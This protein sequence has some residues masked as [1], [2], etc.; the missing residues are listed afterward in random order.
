MKHRI[1]TYDKITRGVAWMILL[2]AVFS[3]T[4]RIDIRTEDAPERLVIYGYITNDTTN[5]IIRLTR[6]SGYFSVNPPEGLTDAVVT[7]SSENEV[8]HL[9]ESP[10]GSGVYMTEADVCG[11]AGETYSLYVA[12]DFD[13]DGEKEEFGASSYMPY[14]ATVDYIGF[15]ESTAIDGVLE[16]LLY[17]KSAPNEENYY[18]F[19]LARNEELLN[20]SLNGVFIISDEYLQHDEFDGLSCFFID[21]TSERYKISA[22]DWVS[23]RVDV[24]TNEY[25]DF[26]ENAADEAGG[27]VPIFSGPPANVETNIRSIHN[28]REIPVSGFFSAYSGAA[29]GRVFE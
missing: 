22:G 27:S 25:A 19:H 4:E 13:G 5:H 2:L 11:T 29:T 16:I 17:G 7:I 6:S 18:S 10:K 3:C 21:Q 8:F 15:R 12:V 14:P 23:L 1:N 9:T 28:P 24:L 20:D 26:M